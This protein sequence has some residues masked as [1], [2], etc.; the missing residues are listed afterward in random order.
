MNATT[1]LI[2]NRLMVTMVVVFSCRSSLV[3]TKMV[4]TTTPIKDPMFASSLCCRDMLSISGSN[5]NSPTAITETKVPI[6]R[7]SP[8]SVKNTTELATA[9]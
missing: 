2:H 6:D 8:Y 5:K 9:S 1:Q 4:A 7:V 3:V